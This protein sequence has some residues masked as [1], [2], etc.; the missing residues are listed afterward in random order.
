NGYGNLNPAATH[1]ILSRDPRVREWSGVYFGS[2]TLDGHD[3]S[4]LG[5]DPGSRV[6]PPLIKGRPPERPDEMVVGPAT[7]AA[8]HK[9][10]GD[11]VAFISSQGSARLTIVGIATFPTIGQTHTSHTS[12]GFGAVVTHRLIPGFD[13]N[14]TGDEVGDTG[15]Q[16][17]FI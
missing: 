7:A 15:P 4:L 6:L 12:L 17:L 8:L 14:I 5:M 3:T 9:H 13:R 2:G 10:V 16:A 11:S 1:R